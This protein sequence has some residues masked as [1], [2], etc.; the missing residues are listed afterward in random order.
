MAKKMDISKMPGYGWEYNALR[1]EILKRIEMRQQLIS[2]TL[3]LAGIFLSF[4][5]TNEMVTLVYPPL[6]MF[7]AFGW[8]QNDFRIR[9]TAEYIRENLEK[10]DIGL[11]YESTMDADRLTDK[12][13][14]TWRFVVISH[15]G[16]FLFS[17]IMAVG[18]D[19]LQ[20][21]MNFS[22]LRVGLL[23]IDAISI[24]MVAWIT[25]QSTSMPKKIKGKK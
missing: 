13:L 22:P 10:L 6:A 16:I 3:T 25:R 7:L 15:S 21:G 2:I 4:G 5:L 20:S 24:L 1:G 18:I 23:T 14:A 12:S 11:K 8:A 9:R 17:Q 19:L